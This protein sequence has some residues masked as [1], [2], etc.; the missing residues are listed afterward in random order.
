MGKERESSDP[1]DLDRPNQQSTEDLNELDDNV[2]KSRS[3]SKIVNILGPE[4]AG[5]KAM[6]VLGSLSKDKEA[7]EKANEKYTSEII[8]ERR[9][10]SGRL[11]F[12]SLVPQPDKSTKG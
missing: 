10:I 7:K 8:K 12:R 5:P 4:H 6:L 1:Q 9:K 11:S 2:R 3:L